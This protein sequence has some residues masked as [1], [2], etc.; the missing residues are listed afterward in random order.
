MYYH[1]TGEAGLNPIF[2]E[3][4]HPLNSRA[5]S[6]TISFSST[7]TQHYTH[8]SPRRASDFQWAYEASKRF[9]LLALHAY[10]TWA[11]NY[12]LNSSVFPPG[13]VFIGNIA[14]NTR[15]PARSVIY[16]SSYVHDNSRKILWPALLR[17]S[18][19]RPK[20]RKRVRL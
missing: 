10:T 3:S 5:A 18:T 7:F 4:W 9:A 15:E 20:I 1:F 13:V 11:S 8:L 19:P 12:V 16:G 2:P 6:F 14:S 17:A